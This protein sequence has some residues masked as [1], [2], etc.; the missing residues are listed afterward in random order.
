M[1]LHIEHLI[2]TFQFSLSLAYQETNPLLVTAIPVVLHLLSN[3]VHQISCIHHNIRQSPL[4]V[5]KRCKPLTLTH[6]HKFL[7]AWAHAIW[8]NSSDFEYTN[9]QKQNLDKCRPRRVN[10]LTKED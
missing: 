3:H 8:N 6:D 10:K 7:Q 4:E 5:S 9:P 1:T 2:Q